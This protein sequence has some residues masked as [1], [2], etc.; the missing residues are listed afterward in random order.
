[1]IGDA[2]ARCWRLE[3]N[4]GNER[5]HPKVIKKRITHILAEHR[6]ILQLEEDPPIWVLSL[7]C[8]PQVREKACEPSLPILLA[9]VGLEMLRL[10]RTKPFGHVDVEARCEPFTVNRTL[11]LGQHLQLD[12]ERKERRFV[13]GETEA[14]WREFRLGFRG[15]LGAFNSVF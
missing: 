10:L 14:L 2:N 1:L 8:W 12:F 15:L 4:A 7:L 5:L 13:F 6:S 3:D 9:V 11:D